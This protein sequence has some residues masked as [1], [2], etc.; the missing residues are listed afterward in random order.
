MAPNL[1]DDL[2][3]QLFGGTPPATESTHTEPTLTMDK[4]LEVARDLKAQKQRIMEGVPS[5]MVKCDLYLSG[6]TATYLALS[7]NISILQ[8]E[9]HFRFLGSCLHYRDVVPYGLICS[10]K[11]RTPGE[12][13]SMMA[14][15]SDFQIVKLG[16]IGGNENADNR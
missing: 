4:L 10:A 9:E 16:G 15:H 8:M 11:I 3:A 5:W 6:G 2:N 7:A 1:T 14:G 13:L 12:R